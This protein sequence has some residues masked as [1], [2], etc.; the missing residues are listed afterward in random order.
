VS[1]LRALLVG[2]GS[3]G[4]AWARTVTASPDVCLAGWVDLDRARVA[5]GLE[6][7]GLAGVAVEDGV[8]VGD[9]LTVALEQLSPDFVIDA[10]VPEAHHEVTARC[11]DHR[12]AVLGEKPMATSLAEAR[13]L[14][15]RADA[16]S[17]LFVVSQNRR[18]NTGLTAFRR[19]IGE[20]LGGLGQLNAEFYRAPHFGGFRDEMDSP[21]LLD[22]AIHTFD[23]ARFLAGADPVSVYCVEFNPS[24]S[25]FR[26]AASAVAEFEFVGGIRFS[27]EGS[28]CAQGHQTSWDS[29]WRAVGALG[30]ATWNGQDTPVAEVRSPTPGGELEVVH[31][32]PAQLPGTD[33]SGSLA[34]FVHALR[35][36]GP[37][38]M[39]ECHD[40]LKS[41]AMVMA[42]LESSRSGKRVAVDLDGS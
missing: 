30:S 28:W 16:T 10:A 34:D 2:A 3:M 41:F 26:G 33:I 42:A 31:A 21:L 14:V 20:R 37:A 35:N 40:N 19:L 15:A 32:P 5:D 27:Y 7:L 11:L 12:V 39:N 38:P 18:Y 6:Q 17:T 9:D 22:M 23:A 36:G 13:D 25:W 29:S 4:R 8:A 24:W 1:R